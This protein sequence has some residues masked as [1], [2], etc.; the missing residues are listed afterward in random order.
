[1]AKVLKAVFAPSRA[2]ALLWTLL[3]LTAGFMLLDHTGILDP[4]PAVH[5]AF[6]L[7]VTAAALTIAVAQQ[8]LARRRRPR[9]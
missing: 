6:Y 5:M 3:L 7:A 9:K 2:I 4:T 1:M 8:I